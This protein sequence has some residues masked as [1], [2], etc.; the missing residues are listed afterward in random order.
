MIIAC[1]HNLEIDCNFE[2]MVSSLHHPCTNLHSTPF[3]GV[4]GARRVRPH[5]FFC[6]EGGHR[7]GH[8]PAGMGTSMLGLFPSVQIA[9]RLHA[10]VSGWPKLEVNG[11]SFI[12]RVRGALV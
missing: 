2:I 6:E 8:R 3:W 5:P 4:R 7:A 9:A 1:C 12:P 10:V 11:G